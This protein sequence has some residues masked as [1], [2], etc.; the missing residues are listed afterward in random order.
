VVGLRGR[1]NERG[2]FLVTTTP[3]N[4][5][6]SSVSNAEM[7]FPHLVDGGGYKTQLVLFSGSTGQ[8][9]AGTL[10]FVSQAG[11]PLG[12]VLW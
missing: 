5:E 6:A 4:N 11:Q 12:L 9:S 10:V 8:K 3:P 1:L 7:L 2:D